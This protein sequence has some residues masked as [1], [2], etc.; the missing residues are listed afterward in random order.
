MTYAGMFFLSGDAERTPTTTFV[1]IFAS[2]ALNII[3]FGMAFMLFLKGL[4]RAARKISK[5]SKKVSTKVKSALERSNTKQRSSSIIKTDKPS[6]GDVVDLEN[7]IKDINIDFRQ[8]MESNMPRV[9]YTPE[10]TERHLL[11]SEVFSIPTEKGEKEDGIYFDFTNGSFSG[12]NNDIM[13]NSGFSQF[14]ERDNNTSMMSASPISHRR[15]VSSFIKE[16][17]RN[18]SSFIKESDRNMSEN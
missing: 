1:L 4:K 5:I 8:N 15:N 11:E 2:I 10:S 3:F 13:R 16:S 14:W 12:K 18:V 9:M 6:I 7:I 17:D